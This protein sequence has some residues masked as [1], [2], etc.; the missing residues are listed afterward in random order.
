MYVSFGPIY[1]SELVCDNY[2]RPF[3]F[4]QTQFSIQGGTKQNPVTI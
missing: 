1:P 3:T 2:D 4:D